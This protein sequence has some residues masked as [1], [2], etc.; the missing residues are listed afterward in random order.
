V[1]TDTGFADAFVDNITIYP[2]FLQRTAYKLEALRVLVERGL[3]EPVID[4]V[5]PLSAVAEAHRDLES[6]GVAGKI[7]LRVAE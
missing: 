2:T 4:R 5:M 6:G 7:V 1:S 3:L